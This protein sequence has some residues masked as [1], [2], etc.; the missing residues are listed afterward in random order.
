MGGMPGN[1]LGWKPPRL[2]GGGGG[3][4]P[5]WDLYGWNPPGPML[6]PWS[7]VRLEGEE[8]LGGAGVERC[9]ES[10]G[11]PNPFLTSRRE[12]GAG[13]AGGPLFTGVLTLRCNPGVS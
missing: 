10:P 6:T 4:G 7:W 9:R 8:E 11:L 13:L 2:P 12:E 5:R 3:G 1:I